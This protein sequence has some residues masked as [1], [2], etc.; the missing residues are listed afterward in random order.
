METTA[1]H[2]SAR[3]A[4]T[5]QRSARHVPHASE[6]STSMSLKHARA[7]ATALFLLAV[8]VAGV[9]AHCQ[10]PCG[11]YNDEL[12]IDLM[13]EDIQTIEKSATSIVELSKANPIDYNQLVRWIDNKEEH[14]NKLQEIITQY[15]MAQRIKPADPKDKTAT[16]L[17]ERQLTLLHA[18]LIEA[19]K[20][21]QT[22]NLEPVQKLKA[23]VG[24]FY[25]AY[26]GKAEQENL[27]EHGH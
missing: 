18:M 1:V 22:T 16:S 24:E 5:E 11:I 12:R 2:R 21:K 8:Q 7:F 10:I 4:K 14:A 23:L 17:Y 9:H 6:R 25:E 19:M 3:E 13:K 27:K 15:F 26:F 20:A